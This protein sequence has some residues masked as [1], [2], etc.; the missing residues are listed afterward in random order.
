MTVT[1]LVAFERDNDAAIVQKV[2]TYMLLSHDELSEGEVA[3][4]MCKSEQWVLSAKD[5]VERHLKR[6]DQGLKDFVKKT[7][8]SEVAREQA[9]GGSK[10]LEFAKR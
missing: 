8:A 9:I 4:V 3:E 7:A 10:S 2:A 5:Y 6:G 1:E